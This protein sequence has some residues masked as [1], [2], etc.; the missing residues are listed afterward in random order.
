[1]NFV[2]NLL[3]TFGQLDAA[4][5]RGVKENDGYV[6]DSMKASVNQETFPPLW[7][8]LVVVVGLNLRRVG[9]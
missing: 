6:K 9:N 3:K 7:N 5:D 1:M 2:N 8:H 4:Q